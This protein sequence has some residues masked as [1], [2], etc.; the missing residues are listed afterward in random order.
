[1]LSATQESRQGAGFRE[2]DNELHVL[3]QTNVCQMATQNVQLFSNAP[4]TRSPLFKASALRTNKTKLIE[5]IDY[6]V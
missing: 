5:Y 4:Y 1:M 3:T 2:L 6:C